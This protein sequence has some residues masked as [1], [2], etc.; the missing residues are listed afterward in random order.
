M[1]DFIAYC[2]LDCETCEARL[3]TI[4]NDNELRESIKT[5]MNYLRD[6]VG[7]SKITRR[8]GDASVAYAFESPEEFIAEFFS[9]PKLQELAKSVQAPVTETEKKGNVFQRIVNYIA[10]AMRSLLKRGDK[11][12]YDKLND[13]L[14]SVV[15]R[16]VQL[17][18]IGKMVFKSK[19]E[20]DQA[21]SLAAGAAVDGVAMASK[22]PTVEQTFDYRYE[23]MPFEDEVLVPS[24]KLVIGPGKF[25]TIPQLVLVNDYFS[26]LR[27]M[28]RF[29]NSQN[30]YWYNSATDS[31]LFGVRDNYSE[32]FVIV[33]AYPANDYFALIKTVSESE[34]PIIIGST[35]Q[36]IHYY[37]RAGLHPV[38]TTAVDGIVFMANDAFTDEY[39]YKLGT[40]Y[41]PFADVLD[42][43]DRFTELR[44]QRYSD[45][46]WNKF[47]E[48][49]KYHARKCIGI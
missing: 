24:S 49:E 32:A 10:N 25:L 6:A 39:L 43:T 20:F 5:Q 30:L 41:R 9:N 18:E 14:Y 48:L 19:A 33:R 36:D 3:A 15:D 23:E 44:R 16:Q 12:F 21:K 47:S 8:L 31:S 40:T 27:G 38:N 34:M 17:Q 42:A 22:I 29:V 26:S 1:K 11:S 7:L 4:N 37:S 13:T 28:K 46:E 2:G 45:E 35:E